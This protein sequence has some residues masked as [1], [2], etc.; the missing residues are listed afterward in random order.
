MQK[1][2]IYVGKT[3]ETH[4]ASLAVAG[5]RELI[6]KAIPILAEMPRKGVEIQNH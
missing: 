2:I 5:V 4:E 3:K 1:E 6:G